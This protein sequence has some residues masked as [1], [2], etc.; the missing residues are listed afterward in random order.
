VLIGLRKRYNLEVY[1]KFNLKLR[2][3][4]K[5]LRAN[6]SLKVE[7]IAIYIVRDIKL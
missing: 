2:I 4:Y 7:S 6:K 5:E 1:S 3:V